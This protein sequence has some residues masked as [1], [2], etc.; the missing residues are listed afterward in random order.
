[1]I[2]DKSSAALLAPM[3]WAVLGAC[4][5]DALPAGAGPDAS[6]VVAMSDAEG[7]LDSATG[8][9]PGAPLAVTQP[10]LLG[11]SL[12]RVTDEGVSL[13]PLE[14]PGGE[15]ELLAWP[16]GWEALGAAVGG[17]RLFA[18]AEGDGWCWLD[19]VSFVDGAPSAD[20][21]HADWEAAGG[22]S[23]F[24]L[25]DHGVLVVLRGAGPGEDDTLVSL[26][27]GGSG[28]WAAKSEVSLPGRVTTGL[29]RLRVG[30]AHE[31]W[32][33]ASAD[34]LSLVRVST[35]GVLTLSTS[36]PM[37][38]TEP[39]EQ[40]V[41]AGGGRGVLVAGDE[42]L[43]LWLSEQDALSISPTLIE[44]PGPVL[45]PLVVATGCPLQLPGVVAPTWCSD[46][47]IV[48]AGDGWVRAWGLVDGES[49]WSIELPAELVTGLALAADSRVL[50]VSVGAEGTWRLRAFAS[51]A[52]PDA[53]PEPIAQGVA[54]ATWAT[55]PV[56]TCGGLTGLV[57]WDEAGAAA[58][59]GAVTGGRGVAPGAWSA[60][61]GSV[62]GGGRIAQERCPAEWIERS[63]MAVPRGFACGA[64][65][66]GRVYMAGGVSLAQSTQFGPSSAAFEVLDLDSGVW[67]PLPSMPVGRAAA[68]CVI[69]DG[70]LY[71]A[72]GWTLDGAVPGLYVYDIAAGSW[73]PSAPM[74]AGR[75]WSAGAAF[76]GQMYVMGGVGTGY[77][78]T[79]ER[80]DPA[81]GSWTPIGQLTAGRYLLGAAATEDALYVVGGD[82]Y[83]AD[84]VY[85][86]IERYDP[87]TN[88]WQ[89]VG[90]LPGPMSG[91]H[92][93]AARGGF[94][95]FHGS[96]GIALLDP[97][98]W[99]LTGGW[100]LPP[101]L[102][103]TSAFVATDRGV[104][105]A[106]GGSWGP[107]L[108]DVWLLGWEAP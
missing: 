51:D 1:M 85:D 57:T 96:T 17:D 101:P 39:P 104:L 106:G 65:H 100:T 37:P 13:V 76:N 84:D 5:G 79:A 82:N 43:R 86:W 16:A 3:C 89:V 107:N 8:V 7:A 56:T 103:A 78:A 99:S 29:A 105:V 60:P 93:L 90:H 23:T 54:G 44:A 24:G 74:G 53:P 30:E 28:G 34:A 47:L 50:A 32:A 15:S 83:D 36:A 22:C 18:L 87:V 91:V 88:T 2:L 58:V 97:A 26:V 64:A 19:V 25:S 62:E 75:A 61:R 102:D 59:H 35:T 52:A 55:G 9:A 20:V 72:G 94:A 41:A 80:Y 63:P 73:A 69:L 6:D 38:V 70:R 27:E 92:L 68:A 48:G 21:D 71:V 4:S 31:I 10:V 40:V 33:A 81:A 49:A 98:G 67:S 46:E 108:S 12:V 14:A 42:V 11:E 66:D 77:L 45:A 95:F